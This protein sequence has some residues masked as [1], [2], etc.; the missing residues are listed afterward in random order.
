MQ[1]KAPRLE[2]FLNVVILEPHGKS[3]DLLQHGLFG[4]TEAIESKSKRAR[5][6]NR[7]NN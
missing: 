4:K 5:I 1:K 7:I 3:V 6:E 2:A